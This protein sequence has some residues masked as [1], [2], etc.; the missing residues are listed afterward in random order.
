MRS[1]ITGVVG[2]ISV[3]GL[4]SLGVAGTGTAA[5]AQSGR[6]MPA[7]QTGAVAAGRCPSSRRVTVYVGSGAGSVIPVRAATKTA[8]PAVQVGNFPVS[9]AVAPGGK[10][11]YV[12]VGDDGFADGYVVPVRVAANAADPE[13]LVGGRS[14]G[15]AITPNGKTVYVPDYE[16]GVVFPIRTA[17]NTAGAPISVGFG[18]DAIAIT[19]NGKTAYVS[20]E[21]GVTPI[22]TATD[23]AGQAI[24]VAGAGYIAI[25]PNGKT[26]LVVSSRGVTR[27]NTATGKAGKSI[28]AGKSPAA[29]AITPNGKT[30]YVANVGS[31]TVT[32]IDIA[33]RAVVRTIS[34]GQ[35]TTI[36]LPFNYPTGLIAITPNGKTAFVVS[37]RGVTPINTA[38]NRAGK[39]IKA[40]QGPAYIAITPCGNT[41]YVSDNASDTI[42]PIST[43]TGRAGRAITVGDSPGAI[44]IAP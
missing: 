26:A 32:V 17:T 12:A 27:I 37:R 43:A 5:V 9:L 30:A 29:I 8:G 21:S 4:V 18:A 3:A 41:A 23:K 31:G 13:I 44:A 16:E 38:T 1:P 35:P 14:S 6:P 7:T 15:I 11:V 2:V 24:K 20:S 40:G 25:T 10:T 39:V 22:N 19:P 33:T 28:K 36:S 34:V 42:T